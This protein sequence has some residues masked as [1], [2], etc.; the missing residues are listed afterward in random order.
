MAAAAAVSARGGV[1]VMDAEHATE[2]N[3]DDVL[4]ILELVMDRSMTAFEDAG[5][6]ARTCTRVAGHL[7]TMRVALAGAHNVTGA[8]TQA[9]FA[10]LVEHAQVMVTQAGDLAVRALAAAELA[11]AAD[12]AF[13]DKY[14]PVQLAAQDAQLVGGPS[15][16]AHNKE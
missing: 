13:H 4:Q 7:D 14:R 10:V 6:L 12:R 3:L 9:A 11:E 1:A 16:R 5:T 15:A 8:R 2:I